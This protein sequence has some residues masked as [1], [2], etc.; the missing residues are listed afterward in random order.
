MRSFPAILTFLGLLACLPATA[1]LPQ[2]DARNELQV[3]RFAMQQN[4]YEE[5]AEHFERANKMLKGKCFDCLAGLAQVR[6]ATGKN[7]AALQ[8]AQRALQVAKTGRQ[9]AIAYIHRATA[10]LQ[11]AET[12]ATNRAEAAK[13]SAHLAQAET[14]FRN[15]VTADAKCLDCKFNV[16]YVLLKQGKDAE[17]V[18][19]LKALL[20]EAKGKPIEEDIRKLLEKPQRARK[21]FAPEFSAML[22]TGE[23]VSLKQLQGKMV[24]LDFW[25]AWCQPCR[26]SLPSLKRLA[27]QLDPAKA[28]VI[29]IDERD[30]R[31]TWAEFVEQNGM[32]WP[33]IYDGNGKLAESFEVDSAPHYFL[34]DEEGAILAKYDGWSTNREEELRKKMEKAMKK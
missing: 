19:V 15:A 21:E 28:V 32:S 14:A 24:L 7:Q 25:G 2:D 29:S 22:K 3:A 26:A 13:A 4:D 16:G 18:Q 5:A 8:D 6:L 10:F 20:P 27:G 12:S 33:Q 31:E 11:M 17:G 9:K 34:L 23:K 1:Q 30:S